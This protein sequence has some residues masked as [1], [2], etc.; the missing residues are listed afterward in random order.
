[1]YMYVTLVHISRYKRFMS[2]P[3]H[4]DDPTYSRKIPNDRDPKM[5][6]HQAILSSTQKTGACAEQVF[7]HDIPSCGGHWPG[8]G[9]IRTS[10]CWGPGTTRSVI[11]PAHNVQC[12]WSEF[13]GRAKFVVSMSPTLYGVTQK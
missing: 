5:Q 12:T 3:L 4:K 6:L 11:V 1:M 13:Y 2:V 8:D 10:G 9:T 7:M